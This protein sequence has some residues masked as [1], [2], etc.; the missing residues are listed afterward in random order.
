MSAKEAQPGGSAC[1]NCGT[2]LQGRYCFSCGQKALPPR[3]TMGDLIMNF[4]GSFTSFES[5]FFITFKYLLLKPGQMI[6]DYNNGKRERYYHPARM[7][8]FLSFVFFLL[9][10]FRPDES[11]VSVTKNGKNLSAQEEKNYL[12]S[13]QVAMDTVDWG[14]FGVERDPDT[15][16]EYDS[17]ESAKEPHDRDGAV[18]R[19]FTRKNIRWKQQYG[20]NYREMMAGFSNN[21]MENT[22][23]MMFLLLPVFALMLK[24]LYLR[25][26]VYYSEHLVF[27]V[28]FYDF[29]FLMGSFMVLFSYASWLSWLRFVI[30][31]FILF[32]LYKAIRKVYKQSRR[33]TILKFVLLLMMFSFVLLGALAINALVTLSLM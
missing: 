7:Y 18:E 24:L 10:S 1:L 5:K 12:D 17:I 28:F 14:A 2:Q 21:F 31:L 19:F 15:V 20:G 29:L 22:P 8:V 27:T 4:I 9:F 6:W 11:V 33:K 16:D 23:K 25:H 3:Q 13:I 26:D 30:Y 32:Y